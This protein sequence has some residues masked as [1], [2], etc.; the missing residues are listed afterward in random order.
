M[1]GIYCIENKVNQKKYIGKAKD[2]KA[3]WR[4]HKCE[5]NK[6]CHVN[7]HLQSAWNKYGAAAFSFYVI[8]EA[9]KED[10]SALEIQW[11][12]KLD[13]ANKGYNL[14]LGGE[15]QFGRYLTDEQKK[16]LSEINTGANNPNYGMKRSAETRRKMSESAK[17]VKHQPLS[18]KHKRK[19]SKALKGRPHPC[20]NKPVIHLETNKTYKSISEASKATGYSISGISKVCRDGR[21]S[22]Y[23]QHFKDLDIQIC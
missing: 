5:L 19:I 3:R 14:T 9:P 16:H 20:S 18:E 1:T 15:G 10:L 4:T 8:A 11:I 23:K 13:T 6:G 21:G 2:V 22:I 12:K 17:H 7:R